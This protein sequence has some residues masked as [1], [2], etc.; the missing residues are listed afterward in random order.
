MKPKLIVALGFLVFFSLLNMPVVPVL[1][2]IIILTLSLIPSLLASALTYWYYHSTPAERYTVLTTS[3]KSVVVWHQIVSVTVNAQLAVAYILY[4]DLE[5]NTD[6]DLN[7]FTCVLI[8]S[9]SVNP[10]LSTAILEFQVLRAL[11]EL[12]P[13]RVL[14][15]DLDKV[16]YPLAVSVPLF[17]FMAEMFTFVYFGT[18]CERLHLDVLIK[19]LSWKISIVNLEFLQLNLKVIATFLSCMIEGFIRIRKNWSKITSNTRSVIL[20]ILNR[21]TVTPTTQGQ[22]LRTPEHDSIPALDSTQLLADSI[23]DDKN[24]IGFFVIFL[25]IF[26]IQVLIS[27]IV[28]V[29]FNMSFV[30]QDCFMFGL[31][32]YWV[33]ATEEIVSFAKLKYHQQALSHGYF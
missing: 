23:P 33:I 4:G 20:W 21:N 30:V 19:K 8:P 22:D 15:L 28:K 7:N 14:G 3:A 12:Y 16:A 2:R 13:Y 27:L 29:N 11:F 9:I 17:A 10:I 6:T 1:A 5:G 26:I 18:L 31:P 32:I 24:E 25:P